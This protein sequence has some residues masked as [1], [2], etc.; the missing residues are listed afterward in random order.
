MKK[1]L[2]LLGICC[3]LIFL[4]AGCT[5]SAPESETE[6][7]ATEQ[8]VDTATQNAGSLTDQAKDAAEDTAG[9]LLDK[10]QDAA[11]DI[12]K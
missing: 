11:D 8:S 10:A 5:S 2:V 4:L 1:L 9:D 3:L 6:E 7:P 12:T